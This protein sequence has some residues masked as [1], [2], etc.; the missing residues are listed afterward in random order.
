MNI[1]L[2]NKE[3]VPTI[4][5]LN[6][7]NLKASESRHRSKLIKQLLSALESLN[8]S[9]LLL[10]D[11]FGQKDENGKLIENAG[12]ITLIKETAAEYQEERKKL[13]NE[14]VTIEPGQFVKNFEAMV[15]ILEKYDAEISGD[16]AVI[17]DR[18][19]DELGL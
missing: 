19:C 13:L 6:S 17:Y 15:G 18:L 3:L 9:E 11:E 2:Q 4:N 5:F 8:E 7:M 1:K 16:D 12:E 14:E 10:V